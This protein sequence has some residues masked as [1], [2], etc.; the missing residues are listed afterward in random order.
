MHRAEDAF[1]TVTPPGL[2]PTVQAGNNN[3]TTALL[4]FFE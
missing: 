4:F 3:I 1:S 2:W